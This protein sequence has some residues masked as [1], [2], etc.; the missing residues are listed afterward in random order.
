LVTLSLMSIAASLPFWLL[1]FVSML[2]FSLTQCFTR[3]P[4]CGSIVGWQWPGLDN[5]DYPAE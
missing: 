5:T 2:W 1:L 3:C 4:A